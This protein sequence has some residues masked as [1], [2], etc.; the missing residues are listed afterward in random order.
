MENNRKVVIVVVG[1]D[2]TSKEN[3][4][5]ML[6][7]NN[8]QP[9]P[10]L[11]NIKPEGE[12]IESVIKHLEAK[13]YYTRLL[14]KEMSPN[15]WD[16]KKSD[17]VVEAKE[18]AEKIENEQKKTDEMI[19]EKI[20]S[21]E[22]KAGVKNLKI[23]GVVALSVAIAVGGYMV[24]KK[25]QNN[26]TAPDLTSANPS[27]TTQTEVEGEVKQTTPETIDEKI[28]MLKEQFAKGELN[29][30]ITNLSE[31]E[32]KVNILIGYF[33][34]MQ[35]AHITKSEAA[36][37]YLL[38]N[39]I[40]PSEDVNIEELMRKVQLAAAFDPY[41]DWR[42]IPGQEIIA[43]KRDSAYLDIY[44][45]AINDW[46]SAAESRDM[47]QVSSMGKEL[48]ATAYYGMVLNEP[49]IT[50]NNEIGNVHFRNVGY[51]TQAFIT[52]YTAATLTYPGYDTLKAI[53]S[54]QIKDDKI[55]ANHIFEPL[56]GPHVI[57]SGEKGSTSKG[58]EQGFAEQTMI[59]MLD[60]Y[61]NG[62]YIKCPEEIKVMLEKILN[63]EK[64]IE[65]KG[66]VKTYKK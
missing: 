29:Y 40:K 39:G 4:K 12:A 35:K 58:G 60:K 28:V 43:N 24:G 56:A 30:D 3:F 9:E 22:K 47:K 50:Q 64:T 37:F 26:V 61:N 7:S 27:V 33:E 48:V 25:A 32:K 41:F 15:E 42:E 38:I 62:Q 36:D 2:T 44:L 63:E 16:L 66:T 20:S 5:C 18:M 10:F 1:K 17:L 14:F 46:K 45:R 21:A 6:Y 11:D 49:L 52:G 65:E 31:V 55:N 59:M 19:K 51:E 57:P 53:G 23:W 54:V 8:F 34:K 13:G